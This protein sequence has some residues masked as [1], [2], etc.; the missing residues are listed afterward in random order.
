MNTNSKPLSQYDI[1]RAEIEEITKKSLDDLEKQLIDKH[2]NV[3]HYERISYLILATSALLQDKLPNQRGM[4]DMDKEIMVENWSRMQS[5]LG[6]M[7]GFLENEGIYD[8]KRL[9]TNAVLAVI[10]TLFT[11]E[12]ENV[13]KKGVF[14]KL[15]KKY[16]WRSFFT[17]RY[18]NSAA[19]KAFNDFIALKRVIIGAYKDNGELF[20]EADVFVFDEEKH[21]IA[22]VDEL[23]KVGWPKRENIRARGIMAV[24]YKLGA[25]DFADGSPLTRDQLINSKRHYHHVFPQSIINHLPVDPN[26]ALNCALISDKTNLNI[27]NKEPLKYLKERYEWIDDEVVHHRLKSHLIPIKELSNGGYKGLEVE[28]KDVKL[29]KDYNVFLLKRAEYVVAAIQRLTD[30]MDISADGVINSV[31]N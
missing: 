3:V 28:K 17:D 13:D 9:P 1:I 8:K 27:G 11:F 18:E 6:K 23:M 14:K 5:G 15:L 4:W 10:A 30:G 7:I 22:G 20:T 31:E 16:L 26:L 25:Y 12:P 19:S 21:P 24:F 2:P 29:Q